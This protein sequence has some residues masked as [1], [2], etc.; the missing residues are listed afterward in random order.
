MTIYCHF[1]NSLRLRVNNK[2][3]YEGRTKDGLAPTDDEGRGKLRYNLGELQTNIDPG[4]S[5]WGNPA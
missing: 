2:L 3:S 5:E 4:V 1:T